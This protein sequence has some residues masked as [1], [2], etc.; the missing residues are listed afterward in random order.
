MSLWFPEKTLKREHSPLLSYP[1]H[2]KAQ[3]LLKSTGHFPSLVSLFTYCLLIPLYKIKVFFCVWLWEP[4]R[5]LKLECFSH[6]GGLFFLNKVCFYLNL[7]LFLFDTTLLNI[8]LWKIKII[9]TLAKFFAKQISDKEFE[10]TKFEEQYLVN[11]HMNHSIKISKSFNH[12]PHNKKWQI[13]TWKYYQ[14]YWTSGKCK[15]KSNEIPICIH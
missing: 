8:L 6:C 10:F 5:F 4:S 1:D 11:K 15:V 9:H 2:S 13:S 12:T 7:D 14:Y 3:S